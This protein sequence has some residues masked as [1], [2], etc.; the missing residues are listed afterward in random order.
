MRRAPLSAQ[1]T[2]QGTQKVAWICAEPLR[3]KLGAPGLWRYL[4]SHMGAPESLLDGALDRRC[5][6]RPYTLPLILTFPRE[7]GPARVPIFQ[8]R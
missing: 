1:E 5:R 4:C 8:R 6:P 2:T 3:S 7:A